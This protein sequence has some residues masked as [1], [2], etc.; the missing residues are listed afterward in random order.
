MPDGPST[1]AGKNLRPVAPAAAA[2]SASVGVSTPGMVTMPFCAASEITAGS[3][4]GLTINWP[5]TSASCSTCA[6]VSTVPA[7]IRQFSGAIFTAVSIERN[8][9]GEFSGISI[10]VKPVSISAPTTPSVSSGLR[11]R[12]IA[13]SGYFIGGKGMRVMSLSF[14]QRGQIAWAAVE[15]PAR[16]AVSASTTRS[17]RSRLSSAA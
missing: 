4:F 3:T 12:R 14:V 13:I 6:V 17:G 7:P 8:G 9:S 15:R 2:E 5:P 10:A 1:L 16:T 11:P